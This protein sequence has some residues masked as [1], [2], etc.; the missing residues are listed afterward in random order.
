MIRSTRILGCDACG[1]EV[2]I[3]HELT[4]ELSERAKSGEKTYGSGLEFLG[5]GTIEVCAKCRDEVSDRFRASTEKLFRRKPNVR[6]TRT[7]E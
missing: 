7:Q 1:R 3:L 6:F 5:R 4:L 2:T